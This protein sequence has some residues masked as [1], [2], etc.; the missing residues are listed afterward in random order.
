MKSIRKYI[1]AA[2]LMLSALSF[3]PSPA[4]AQN[5]AGSFTLTNEV[6]WQTCDC[7]GGQ[8]PLHDWIHRSGR[9]AD[10]AQAWGRT[11][12]RSC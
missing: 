7:A 8:L 12:R 2:L 3:S 4:S 11:E 10:A 6:H 9:D 1:Y 5:A